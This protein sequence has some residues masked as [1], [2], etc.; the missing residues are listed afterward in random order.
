MFGL[1]SRGLVLDGWYQRE[2]QGLCFQMKYEAVCNPRKVE[3]SFG[4]GGLDEEKSLLI[5]SLVN[6][7]FLKFALI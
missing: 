3:D 4:K 1:C 7:L 6:P 2:A 5:F